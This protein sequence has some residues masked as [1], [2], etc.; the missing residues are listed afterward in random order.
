[1]VKNFVSKKVQIQPTCAA[2]KR[3]GVGICLYLFYCRVLSNRWGGL[4]ELAD[5]YLSRYLVVCFRWKG[6]SG[7]RWCVLCHTCKLVSS[8]SGILLH[9]FSC[10]PVCC[11]F[12][13]WHPLKL[14][15]LRIS[16]S[17]DISGSIQSHAVV[18]GRQQ[19]LTIRWSLCISAPIRTHSHFH[20]FLQKY[21]LV[22][23]GSRPHPQSKMV[24]GN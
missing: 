4:R 8:A 3:I 16:M 7:R 6:S 9:S 23:G 20:F 21:L 22:R 17:F 15:K 14:S 5:C 1:M 12:V 19:W 13:L 2:S 10:V 11:R 18:H 24:V